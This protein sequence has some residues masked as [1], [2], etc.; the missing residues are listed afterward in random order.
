MISVFGSKVGQEEIDEIRTSIENQWIGIGLKTKL[1]EEN[2]VNALN[3]NI[4]QI[5]KREKSPIE[6]LNDRYARGEIT[7]I[8]FQQKIRLLK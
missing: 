6:I 7:D 5:A 8:D 4:P 3:Y 1:F 2:P